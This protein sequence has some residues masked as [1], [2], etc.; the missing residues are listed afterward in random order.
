MKKWIAQC[1]AFIMALSLCACGGADSDVPEKDPTTAGNNNANPGNNNANPGNSN[2]DSEPQ[3]KVEVFVLKQLS[4]MDYEYEEGEKLTF[5]YDA[6]GNLIAM[7]SP[8]KQTTFDK[9]ISRPLLESIPA[10]QKRTVSTY[11]AAGRLLSRY[12]FDDDDGDCEGV[13]YT[14]DEKGNLLCVEEYEDYSLEDGTRY[15]YDA[16]GNMLTETQYDENGEKY[17]TTYTYNADGKLTEQTYTYGD[18]ESQRRVY[19]YNDNGALVGMKIYRGD[20]VRME[21]SLTYENVTVSKE[22]AKKLEALVAAL[23]M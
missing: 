5:E 1:L 3:K 12:E 17:W 13:T 4:A 10:R 20:E 6:L 19:T 11:D 9:H 23:G 18:E 8:T 2:N 14:Y 22:V 7:D 21:Y 16:N 15:T